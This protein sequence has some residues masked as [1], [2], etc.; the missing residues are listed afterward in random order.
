MIRRIGSDLET[1]KKLEFGPGLNVLLADKSE[2]ASDRQSRNRAGKTSFVEIV[3]FLTG[4][5]VGK[6]SIFRSNALKESAFTIQMDVG[7]D[8]FTV[9]RSG[10]A[11]GKVQVDGPVEG[12]PIASTFNQ[13]SG[14]FEISNTN[15]SH[16]LGRKWFGL[17]APPNPDT[18][19]QPT[20]RS[21][22]S[23]FV[24]RQASGGFN[25]P[26]QHT[27]MQQ[28]WDQQVAISY[29]LGLDWSVSQGF[30]GFREKEKIAKSLGKA[31]RSVELGPYFGR[32]ADL[33]TRLAVA[34]K[35]TE[36]IRDQLDSFAIIP[37]YAEL[38]AEASGITGQINALGEENFVDRRLIDDLE[39]A[40]TEEQAPDRTDLTKLYAEAGVILPDLLKRR[41][42][43]VEIFHQTII[44][45]RQSHLS[46]ELISAQ[47]RIDAR[48]AEKRTLDTR[49]RQ[50]MAVLQSGGAL[51][52]YTAMRE[53]QGRVEA[54]V[55]TLRRRLD[56]AETLESTQAEL[57]IERNRLEQALRDD[58]HERD[59]LLNEAIVGFEELSK[60]LYEQAG[61]LTIGAGPTGPS[62][63]IRIDGHRSKGI[64][65]M[66]I[67][68]FDLMM[69]ELCAR[70]G[71][72]PGFLIHD[73]HLFD[74]VDERQVAK[75][76]QLGAERAETAGFQYIVT[77]NSD[78]IPRDGFQDSFG[79][80]AH[81]IPTRLTDATEDGG[82]FG[83][84]FS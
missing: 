62:F 79:I 66:Q 31:A 39:L 82:L 21:L 7:G 67:F 74:G 65:N 50:I 4:G 58:I 76:L 73:S 47:N 18:K 78:V 9:A 41:L 16:V 54:E 13:D 35:R 30:Q 72:S 29:L 64:T 19:F 48:E 32:A 3:H 46:A 63:E 25:K 6:D 68:C 60:S 55:E 36:T 70:Y 75:A 83:I 27:T 42:D 20:F 24:R 51:E 71:R 17:D 56:T 22:F 10:S 12:W 11:P 38:E 84:R 5:N 40:L 52:Q 37:Q 77:M 1:F 34:A 80:N 69:T 14:V 59:D 81:V 23:Y 61:S 44:E 2:G 15:W 53:E 28:T 45:N 8:G 49:R 33:R 43:E 26:T 57:T